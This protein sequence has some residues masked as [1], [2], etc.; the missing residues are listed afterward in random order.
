M[1]VGSGA[2]WSITTRVGL[3]YVSGDLLAMCRAKFDYD[4]G[5]SSLCV[6]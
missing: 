3:R 4:Q 6:G 1:V 5:R 2:R